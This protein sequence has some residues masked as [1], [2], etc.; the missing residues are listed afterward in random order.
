M[1]LCVLVKQMVAQNLVPRPLER[2]SVETAQHF[3]KPTQE[4]SSQSRSS[5]LRVLIST[6][7]WV[8]YLEEISV[9]I[10]NGL[11][12]NSPL[13]QPDTE[14]LN[15][16]RPARLKVISDFNTTL[17]AH[18]GL[19]NSSSLDLTH[20][21]THTH[22]QYLLYLFTPGHS[23]SLSRGNENVSLTLVWATGST[24]QHLQQFQDI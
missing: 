21:H 14:E 9:L 18:Q 13:A 17:P 6:V 10:T 4:R 5:K 15:C 1:N 2:C 19:C 23:A 7:L 11:L 22:T 16:R 20:T 12:A 24:R 3:L 8:W